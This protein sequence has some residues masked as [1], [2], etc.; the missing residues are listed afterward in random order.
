MR[1]IEHE[2]AGLLL[3]AADHHHRFT[4]IGLRMARRMRQRH[5][6]FLAALIPLAHVILDDRIAAGEATLV[7]QPIEHTLGGMA[8]LA[9]HLHVRI[10]PLV[11]RRHKRIQL[12][13]P[14]R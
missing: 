9:R 3:D 12:R 2:E 7:T 6:D 11:D 14:D 5:E 10:E 4:E 8:L 13:P 1:Q